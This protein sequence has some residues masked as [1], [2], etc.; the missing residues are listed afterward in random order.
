VTILSPLGALFMS[1]IRYLLLPLVL[2][3]ALLAAGCGGSDEVPADA[4]AVVGDRVIAKEDFDALMEQAR[5]SYAAQ[6]SEENPEGR[7]FPEAGTPEHNTL[8]NQAVQFLVQRAQFEQK[9]EELGIEVTDEMVEERLEQIK[10]QYFEG[11]E[12]KYQEQIEEQGL[13]DAQVRRDIRAQLVQEEIFQKVTEDIE[14]ADGEVEEY[15]TENAEQYG[16]PESREVRHILVATEDEAKEIRQKLEAGEDFAKLAEEH[17]QDPGSA[18][19]GGKL[20]VSRGQTVPEFDQTAFSLET[21][22]IS[23]P[24]KTQY[25][26]HIIQP[27]SQVKDAETTPLEDVKES[28][29]QQLLQT[30]RNEKMTEWVEETKQEFA[31][32]TR[33]QVGFEPP[34]PETGP[35]ENEDR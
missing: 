4:I 12:E 23:Q 34:E 14:V 19:Q 25:G 13:E 11:D 7:P 18:A 3:G 21:N 31:E 35:T 8:K 9:A 17:S 22:S 28:I 16:Q 33:Y 32:K 1:Q 24:V 30:K 6:T 20:T 5:R 26:F 10:E 15:Y 2:V 29:R 27:L